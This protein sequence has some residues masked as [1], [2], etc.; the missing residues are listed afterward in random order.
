VPLGAII[1]AAEGLLLVA[2]DYHSW[3]EV[4]G[5]RSDGFADSQDDFTC[6]YVS[7]G[8]VLQKTAAVLLEEQTEVDSGCARPYL[9]THF[10]DY[11]MFDVHRDHYCKLTVTIKLGSKRPNIAH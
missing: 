2:I 10:H 7:M 9:R 5:A 1:N 8:K 3:Y 11:R 6:Y 4:A